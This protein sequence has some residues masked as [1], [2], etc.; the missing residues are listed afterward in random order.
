MGSELTVG[1][2]G[3][4][5]LN[6]RI[7]WHR[8]GVGITGASGS[9]YTLSAD[10][11][12]QEISAGVEF[13]RAGYQTL[14]VMSPPTD[15]VRGAPFSATYADILGETGI[16]Q[17]LSVETEGWT[18]TPSAFGFQWLVDGQEVQGATSNEYEVV[19]ADFGKRVSV[20]VTGSLNGYE[21][22]AIVA[23]ASNDVVAELAFKSTRSPYLHPT[24]IVR[25]YGI[26]ESTVGEDSASGWDPEPT[27]WDYQ[28]LRGSVA[29]PGATGPT[30]EISPEDEGSQLALEVTVARSGYETTIVRS[31]LTSAVRE[32][33]S[34]DTPWPPE[35]TCFSGGVYSTLTA[36]IQE[37]YCSGCVPA[38]EP[39]SWAYQWLR[40]GVP[41]AGATERTF[42]TSVSDGGTEISVRVT[43][44]RPNYAPTSRTAPAVAIPE[45]QI[46]YTYPTG[47][48]LNPPS[49]GSHTFVSG[50]I[51]IPSHNEY[52]GQSTQ[53]LRADRYSADF[54]R[55]G[56]GGYA[57]NTRHEIWVRDTFFSSWEMLAAGTGSPTVRL[58]CSCLG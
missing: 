57:T 28:W 17:I 4:E 40:D 2:D 14:G 6:R 12:G 3:A 23:Q 36:T 44:S 29:I 20:E 55:L 19:S 41:I 30:Y 50:E 48:G 1:I 49:C 51:V 18:P 24:E 31:G 26:L 11:V 53:G 13:S 35:I 16:G 54:T 52:I 15:V 33:F 47:S 8:N 32:P 27:S 9:T 39:T 25:A 22:T 38:P 7:I 43:G 37:W 58:T 42:N 46:R 45:A 34:F 56:N 5:G 10:D 21:T